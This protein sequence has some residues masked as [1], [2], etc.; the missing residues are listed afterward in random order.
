VLIDRQG[1]VAGE[2]RKMRPA[3]SEMKMGV[4]PGQS[5]PPVFQTDF[6]KIGIQICFDIKYVF[7]NFNPVFVEPICYKPCL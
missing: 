6:G 5:N 7:E 4:K 2:Y 3:E 1:K